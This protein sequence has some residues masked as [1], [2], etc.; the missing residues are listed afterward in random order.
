MEQTITVQSFKIQSIFQ[1]LFIFA[2]SP[3]FV[4]VEIIMNKKY[5]VLLIMNKT[6][7]FLQKYFIHFSITFRNSW[8]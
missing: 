8:R 4:S 1:N 3:I 5:F 7:L 6:D 2:I